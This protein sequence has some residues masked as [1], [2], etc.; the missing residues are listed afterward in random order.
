MQRRGR[1]W[2]GRTCQRTHGQSGCWVDMEIT[3][4]GRGEGAGLSTPGMFPEVS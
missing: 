2:L 4:I 3:G 1:W